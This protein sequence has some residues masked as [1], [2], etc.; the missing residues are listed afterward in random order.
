MHPNCSTCSTHS[1]KLYEKET[2]AFPQKFPRNDGYFIIGGT[3]WRTRSLKRLE[4]LL[5]SGRG[6]KGYAHFHLCVTLIEFN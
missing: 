6:T 4:R 5:K 1:A 3:M 2:I